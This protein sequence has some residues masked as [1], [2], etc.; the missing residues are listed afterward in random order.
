MFNPYDLIVIVPN[1]IPSKNINILR[2][3]TNQEPSSATVGNSS[4]DAESVKL[5]DRNT[6]WYPIPEDLRNKLNFTIYQAHERFLKPKYNSTL[7]DIEPPQ[8]L[9]Y[10]VGGHYIEHNDSEFFKNGV[11]ERVVPRDIA[12]LYYLNDD[13]EGGEIE[14]TSLGIKF[15]PREGTLLAFPAY[16]E[17]P[18]KVHPVTSGVKHTIVS[19]IITEKKVYETLRLS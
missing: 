17:Y 5:K 1:Y 8:F 4:S 2:E 12:V 9:E 11:W 13:Y 14:L 18:H 7:I 15:K 16:K 3:L 6:L 19:W 10:P